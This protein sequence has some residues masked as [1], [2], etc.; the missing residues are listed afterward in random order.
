MATKRRLR[1]WHARPAGEDPPAGKCFRRKLYAAVAAGVTVTTLGLAGGGSAGAVSTGPQSMGPLIYT[2]SQ[3]GYVT[4]GGRWFR[5][6]TTTVVVPYL[7]YQSGNNG[8]AE[9]VLG[10]R[11]GPPAALRV[12][13]GGGTGSISYVWSNE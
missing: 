5:F 3:A 1:T 4:G 11:V 6:V 13:A 10:S 9:V 7:Q 8:S 12:A 2:T